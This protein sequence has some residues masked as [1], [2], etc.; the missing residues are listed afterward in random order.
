MLFDNYKFAQALK[1]NI[2][3]SCTEPMVSHVTLLYEPSIVESFILEILPYLVQHAVS[4]MIHCLKAQVGS[5]PKQYWGGDSSTLL[6]F[7]SIER[8]GPVL[9]KFQSRVS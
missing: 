4:G 7:L 5:D 2:K 1:L 6:P 3:C 8:V 9:S